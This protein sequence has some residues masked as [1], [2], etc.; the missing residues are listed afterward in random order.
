[1][2]NKALFLTLSIFILFLFYSCKKTSVDLI[3][4]DSYTDIGVGGW[5]G[6][7]G[8]GYDVDANIVYGY[9]DLL[10]GQKYVD[11]FFD[12]SAFF[13]FD[14]DGGDQLPDVGT[15]FANTNI[16]VAQFDSATTDALFRNIEPLQTADSVNFKIDD[17]VLFKTRWGKKAIARIKSMTSPTGDLI[18]DCKAQSR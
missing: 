3:P 8:S 2:R 13:S 12:R 17:V 15:R 10:S 9:G 16:T 1:M 6:A 4:L 11:I 14:A 7:N 18:F 5:Y